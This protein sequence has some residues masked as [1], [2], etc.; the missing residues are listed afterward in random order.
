MKLTEKYWISMA[1]LVWCSYVVLQV[2]LLL[3]CN[4]M[5]A[6]YMLSSC[7]CPAICPSVRLSFHPYVTRL[8]CT[9]TAK[10]KCSLLV[11]V[12]KTQGNRKWQHG[13]SHTHSQWAT[14]AGGYVPVPW[15]RKWW[16][17][18]GIPY[19]V[20]HG[21][22]DWVITKEQSSWR[23]LSCRLCSFLAVSVVCTWHLGF[24]KMCWRISW[25]LSTE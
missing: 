16:V 8:Y 18:D 17:Y 5:L 21:V 12:D 7:I 22:G 13:V 19:Q 23:Q 10:R 11:N 3:P 24:A 20:K 6:R 4:A 9:K 25:K 15:N 14:G 1:A 2:H